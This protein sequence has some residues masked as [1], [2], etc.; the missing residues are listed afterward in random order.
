VCQAIDDLCSYG[1]DVIIIAR[2]GGSIEDMWAFNTEIVADKVFKCSIPV[3]SAI[4]HETDFTICDFVADVRAATPSVAAQVVILD[5][6]EI[7]DRI[8]KIVSVL[9]KHV[10]NRLLYCQKQLESVTS[11]KVFKKP[12]S[13]LLERWQELESNRKSLL[14]ATAVNTEMKKSQLASIISY[15]DAGRIKGRL[16]L[17]DSNIAKLRYILF[18]DFN[19]HI[20]ELKNRMSLLVKDLQSNSPV[21]VLEK[22]YAFLFKKDTRKAVKSIGD[23]ETGQEAEIIL[24][25]GI[26]FAKI[27]DKINKKF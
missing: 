11:R 21:V 5:K 24:F 16:K 8:N 23:I 10:E 25:D 19:K 6:R 17:H 26:L 3:I 18:S 2:G 27:L 4:G 20:E 9:K 12:A 14:S 22:G 15:I 13:L 1:V 7:T